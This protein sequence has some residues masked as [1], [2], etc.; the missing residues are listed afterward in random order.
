MASQPTSS[1]PRTVVIT[2][3]SRGLGRASAIYLHSRG[4]HVV[5]TMRNLDG[6]DDLRKAMGVSKDDSR[7]TG[8]SL[9]LDDNASIE[10]AAKAILTEVGV[11]DAIVH[12]AGVAAVGSAEEMTPESLNQVFSTNFFGPVQ[13]TRELLPAMR[14]AGKGRVV[15]VSSLGALRG[16]PATSSYSAAKSALERWAESLAYEV[17][18]S[19]VGVSIL[20]TGTYATDIIQESGIIDSMQRDGVYEN[21]YSAME[22]MGERARKIAA[23]PERFARYLETAL[24]DRG[25]FSRHS[26]GRDAVAMRIMNRLPEGLAQFVMRRVLG[27]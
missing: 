7:L 14:A 2:G 22:L 13:L 26:A 27:I 23:P 8:I 6:M 10:T 3:A 12:N 1:K 11:P 20:V 17:G 9:D 15:V 5:P 25:H 24:N 4:W 19:G 21:L 18:P 16:L